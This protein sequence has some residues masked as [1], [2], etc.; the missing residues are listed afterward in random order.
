MQDSGNYDSAKLLELQAEQRRMHEN[1]VNKNGHLLIKVT[2]NCLTR[3]HL[4]QSKFPY[5]SAEVIS[6][7]MNLDRDVLQLIAD[8]PLLKA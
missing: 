8:T 3:P 2:R 6:V 4:V 1:M 7:L 5:V